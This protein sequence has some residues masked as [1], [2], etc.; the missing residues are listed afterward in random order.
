MARPIKSRGTK[1]HTL[2]SKDSL[3]KQ[4]LATRI[5]QEQDHHF[6]THDALADVD[7]GRVIN[8]QTI[9]D[10]ADR[11]SDGDPTQRLLR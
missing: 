4:A 5:D 8:H 7:A 1:V 6:M 11:L 3:K 9:Q 10:W 2:D